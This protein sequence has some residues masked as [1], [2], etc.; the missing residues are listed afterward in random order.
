MKCAL[1]PN[2]KRGALELCRMRTRHPA[3]GLSWRQNQLCCTTHHPSHPPPCTG[4]RRREWSGGWFLHWWEC[5]VCCKR[6]AHSENCGETHKSFWTI[7]SCMGRELV[8][9][10]R[11]SPV[12]QMVKNLPAVQETR[13]GFLGSLRTPGERNGNPLQYSCLGTFMDRGPWWATAHGVTK[14]LTQLS[15]WHTH[16]HIHNRIIVKVLDQ[17]LTVYD[18]CYA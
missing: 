5:R 8:L 3:Q 7:H 11:I 17:S 2:L 1:L 6:L 18:V 13:D 14:S 16:T 15:D 4:N 12:A 10:N 9:G